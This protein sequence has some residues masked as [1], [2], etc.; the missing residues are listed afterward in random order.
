M[1]RL[2]VIILSLLIS[3]SAVFAVQIH[4]AAETGDLETV[5]QLLAEDP[6]LLYQLDENGKPPF[7]RACYRGQIEVAAYLLKQGADINTKSSNG[8]TSLHGAGFYGFPDMANWLLE[9][10]ADPDIPNDAGYTPL[11]SSAIAGNVDIADMLIAAGANPNVTN[12]RGHALIHMYAWSGQTERVLALIDHGVDIDVLNQD[13]DTPLICAAESNVRDLVEILMAR[14]AKL[15]QVNDEGRTLAHYFAQFGNVEAL[16]ILL[17]KHPDLAGAV[18]EDGWTPL[19][20]AARISSVDAMKLIISRGVDL[21]TLT[22]QQQHPIMW[23][24]HADSTDGLEYLLE[25]GVNPNLTLRDNDTPLTLALSWRRNYAVPILLKHGAD[26]NIAGNHGLTALM[27]AAQQGDATTVDLLLDAGA[28]P[29]MQDAIQGQTALHYAAINGY[30]DIAE[31]LVARDADPDIRDQNGATALQLATRYCQK[32][33]ALAL[34]RLG[35]DTDGAKSIIT[36]CKGLSTD[37]P[38][39]D[40]VVWYLGHCGFAI[41][42]ADHFLVFDYWKRDEPGP[43]P[44]LG[45][46]YICP[47]ELKNENVVVFATHHHGDH[48]YH[49]T[50]DWAE[51]ADNVKFVYGFQPEAYQPREETDVLGENYHGPEYTF[52]APHTT[53]ELDGITIN[54]IAANDA[55]VGFLVEVDGVTLFHAGDHAGWNEGQRDG[56][57]AEI[58]YIASL[59]RPIDMAF[60]NVTG[61]HTHG[62]EPLREGLLYALETLHPKAWAPTHAG[63]REWVYRD[64]VNHPDV[65]PWKVIVACPEHPGDHFFFRN[66]KLDENSFSMAR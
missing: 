10:G 47:D 4:V 55:G 29:D 23:A 28:D 8:S 53:T 38:K 49:G 25:S 39:G 58:D 6:S 48:F 56:Y 45:N 60:M 50:Y 24:I 20:F 40:M 3:V 17:E 21:N 11:L 66:G 36:P 13:M 46:G 31:A 34:S 7:N 15:D 22:E 26:P 14:G 35:A 51:N 44:C 64:F 32:N 2:A 43:N 41:K 5:K 52:T 42:T 61:C 54:T 33:T 18:D 37:M 63:D 65:A 9:H 57:V 12:E 16:A 27:L 19:F 1:K 59:N 62:E 30:S